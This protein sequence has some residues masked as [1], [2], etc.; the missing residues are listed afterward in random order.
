MSRN[1]CALQAM[2]VTL[3]RGRFERESHVSTN[4]VE[5]FSDGVIAVIITIMVLELRLPSEASW[6]GLLRVAPGFLS[7][8]LSFVVVAIM[9][10]NHHHMMTA[11][12]RA[13]AA[14]LWANNLLLFCMSVIPFTTAFL[15][16]NY[17]VPFAVA[18]YGGV[19]AA[20]GLS[21]AAFRYVLMRHNAGDEAAVNYHRRVLKKDSFSTIFYLCAAPLA[22]ES[23]KISFFIYVL[24]P[25][26]YFLPERKLAERTEEKQHA[27]H[28]RTVK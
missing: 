18:L 23:V 28:E 1:D 13:D 22:Y 3:R 14:L 2:P 17:K 9:W 4:R 5:A 20:S 26:L 27:P 21:F 24:I 25:A 19:L 16:Q 12:K 11:A 8:V 10:V 7:Y 15:G 6:A